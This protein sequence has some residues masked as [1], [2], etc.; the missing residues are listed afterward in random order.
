MRRNCG[1]KSRGPQSAASRFAGRV[2]SFRCLRA[3]NGRRDPVLLPWPG[4]TAM[5]SRSRPRRVPRCRG[6]SALL[7][8]AVAIRHFGGSRTAPA[9]W[10]RTTRRYAQF[11]FDTGGRVGPMGPRRPPVCWLPFRFWSGSESRL[12]KIAFG[13]VVSRPEPAL[14]A[15]TGKQKARGAFRATRASLGKPCF[16]FR[17]GHKP[18]RKSGLPAAWALCACF[19]PTVIAVR[20]AVAANPPVGFPGTD[21]A[22]D[23]ALFLRTS[24]AKPRRA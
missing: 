1:S 2:A 5:W 9:C 21:E 20:H 22:G 18:P 17:S 8:A 23:A 11:F 13:G 3:P 10:R 15:G 19:F 12:L 24:Q 14:W 6:V 4:V 16:S 7:A